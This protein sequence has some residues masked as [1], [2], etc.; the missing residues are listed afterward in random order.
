LRHK[1]KAANRIMDAAKTKKS[2]LGGVSDEE[3]N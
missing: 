2:L 3:N 1:K